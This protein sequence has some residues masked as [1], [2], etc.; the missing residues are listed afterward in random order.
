MSKESAQ[1][2]PVSPEINAVLKE[3]GFAE[4]SRP[5]VKGW[6][7]SGGF[8]RKVLL[9][10]FLLSIIA[11]S[12]WISFSIGKK[13]FN[14]VFIGQ[15]DLPPEEVNGAV[16]R[17]AELNRLAE[18]LLVESMKSRRGG[19]IVEGEE[20]KDEEIKAS[21]LLQISTPEAPVGTV[22]SR[23]VTVKKQLLKKQGD[24]IKTQVASGEGWPHFFKALVGSFSNEAAARNF[25]NKG[26]K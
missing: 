20:I 15:N 24:E 11:A 7:R 22:E 4:E 2:N 26:G 5:R 16:A 18:K 13:I 1:N 6:R 19:V 9:T 3:L 12:F 23:V 14:P 21:S 17:R 10:L 8:W 25:L